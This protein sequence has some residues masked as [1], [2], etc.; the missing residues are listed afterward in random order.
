MEAIRED[1][2]PAVWVIDRASGGF[3]FD[4]ADRSLKLMPNIEHL[5]LAVIERGCRKDIVGCLLGMENT[6]S[7]DPALVKWAEKKK[8]QGDEKGQWLLEK[9]EEN[10]S[11]RRYR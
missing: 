11:K 5:R 8:E 3:N 2:Y 1:N 4:V 6:I 10:G 7:T 9:L